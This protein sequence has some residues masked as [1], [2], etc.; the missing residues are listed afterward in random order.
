MI[1]A[2]RRGSKE[3]TCRWSSFEETNMM[4]ESKLSQ[5]VG[6]EAYSPRNHRTWPNTRRVIPRVRTKSLDDCGNDE[7]SCLAMVERGGR[8]RLRD[9]WEHR[10]S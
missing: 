1:A 7:D 5:Y 10:I 9:L 3:R 8:S 2:G 6:I 4:N